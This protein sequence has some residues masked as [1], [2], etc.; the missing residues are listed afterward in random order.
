VVFYPQDWFA[1]FKTNGWVPKEIR[2]QTV[3]SIKLGR[4]TPNPWWAKLLSHLMP[5]AQ[6]EE[7]KKFTG[8]V[9]LT[10]ERTDSQH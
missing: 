7:M 4:P 9:L 3:E 6:R 2:Y 5:A 8:Y 10:P 1:F